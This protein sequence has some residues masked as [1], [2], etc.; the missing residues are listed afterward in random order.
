[1]FLL[2]IMGIQLNTL[3]LSWARPPGDQVEQVWAEAEPMQARAGRSD[4]Q[5]VRVVP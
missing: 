4:P 5:V 2:K 1:M 3:E